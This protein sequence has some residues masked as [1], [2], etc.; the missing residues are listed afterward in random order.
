M[1]TET[2]EKQSLTPIPDD[3]KTWL[4]SMRKK[5]NIARLEQVGEASLQIDP[6]SAAVIGKPPPSMWDGSP[7]WPLW[8]GQPFTGHRGRE[9]SDEPGLYIHSNPEKQTIGDASCW[10][11]AE[12][13]AC[14]CGVF[15]RCDV[16]GVKA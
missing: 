8:A 10:R 1:A 13:P 5:G 3:I 14:H 4:E 12:D 7:E 11:V 2:K 16:Y 6:K 9:A 15:L